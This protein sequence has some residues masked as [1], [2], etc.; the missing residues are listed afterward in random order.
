MSISKMAFISYE[1]VKIE[2][3]PKK[4]KDGCYYVRAG[5]IGVKSR[6]GVFYDS[7]QQ[8]RNLF[9]PNS[10]F[11]ERMKDGEIFGE[12]SHPQPTGLS[13]NQYKQ[14][15]ATIEPSNTAF[16][17]TS[18]ELISKGVGVYETWIRV[19]PSGIHADAFEKAMEDDY[20][21][22][23][24]SLRGFSKTVNGIRTLVY[25]VTYDWVH[26]PGIE[27]SSK[28]HV[29]RER[30]W[31]NTTESEVLLDVTEDVFDILNSDYTLLNDSHPN[32]CFGDICSIV[33]KDYVIENETIQ[34]NTTSEFSWFR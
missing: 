14:R 15:L 27:G 7:S 12:A 19:K 11:V 31:T 18:I 26:S 16:A 32:T 6:A 1:A 23:S 5:K 8:V 3:K 17:I 30:S 20:Q 10:R 24:F 2:N 29:A 4:D 9:S 25:I 21:N 13:D 28:R 33:N 22:V 34:E